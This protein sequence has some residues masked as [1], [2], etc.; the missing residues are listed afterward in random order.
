MGIDATVA[1]EFAQANMRL[2]RNDLVRLEWGGAGL[3]VLGIE[4]LW[5][6]GVDWRGTVQHAREAAPKILL[7]HNPDFFP[8]A[9]RHGIDLTLS[10][11]YHGGQIKLSKGP[12]GLTPAMVLSPYLEGMYH[13]GQSHL[14]VNR[15]LG[16][17][18]I[19]MRF[20]ARPEVTLFTLRTAP[21][22][23]VS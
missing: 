7:S 12:R 22:A 3:D 21:E 15:G 10:G 17:T 18:G 6:G 16:T 5:A 9:A 23:S 11:H 19:P 13:L 8:V 1:D 14:Y 4:D 20:N 2:L